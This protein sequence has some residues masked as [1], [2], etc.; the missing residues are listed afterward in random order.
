MALLANPYIGDDE[1]AREFASAD[2]AVL[3]GRCPDC[4]HDHGAGWC[5]ED[6]DHIVCAC[7][8]MHEGDFNCREAVG[9]GVVL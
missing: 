2:D 5:V 3:Y 9:H 6:G 8:L 1:D 7:G 4:G